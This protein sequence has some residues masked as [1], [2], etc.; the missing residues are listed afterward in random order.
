MRRGER[1]GGRDGREVLAAP[2]LE[3]V[4]VC[5]EVDGAADAGDLAADGAE[6]E[7]ERDGRAALDGKGDCAAVAAAFEL[8][9]HR[10]RQSLGESGGSD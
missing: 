1:K 7:L 6:T 9:G 4:S 8:D 3:G 2:D 5:A 10:D